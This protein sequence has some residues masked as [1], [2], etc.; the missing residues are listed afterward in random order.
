MWVFFALSLRRAVKANLFQKTSSPSRKISYNQK[1]YDLET[2]HL[3]NWRETPIFQVN[4][5][6]SILKCL[7]F[8]KGPYRF[9]KWVVISSNFADFSILSLWS[10][11]HA[12]RQL[13]SKQHLYL[14]EA[15]IH[16]YSERSCSPSQF[17]SSYE[18][19]MHIS[20]LIIRDNESW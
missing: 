9:C 6:A 13:P 16:K 20:F 2:V 15:E 8:L 1:N 11:K 5:T 4:T 18:P 10:T 14:R 19:F 17:M 3:K 7:R 12:L